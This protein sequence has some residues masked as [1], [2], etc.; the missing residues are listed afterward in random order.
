[1]IYTVSITEQGQITIPAKI[2][3][4]LNLTKKSKA[5]VSIKNNTMVIEPVPDFLE[6]GGSLKTTKKPLSDQKLDKFISQAV[7]RDYAKE[8]SLA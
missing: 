5:N 3:R 2:R 1:M 6:L 8:N 7:A 4:E